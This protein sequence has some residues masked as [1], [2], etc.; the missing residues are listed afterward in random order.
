MDDMIKREYYDALKMRAD[1]L[2][3]ICKETR[4]ENKQLK[5]SLEQLKHDYET[6]R[7]LFLIRE[8]RIEKAISALKDE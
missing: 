7:T 1:K 8:E 4:E 6:V 5:A 2:E 3:A